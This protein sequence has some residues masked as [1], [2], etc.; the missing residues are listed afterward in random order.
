MLEESYYIEERVILQQL[1]DGKGIHSKGG[2]GGHFS[3][4]TDWLKSWDYCI[5][6][7][8][9]LYRVGLNEVEG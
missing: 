3:N 2:S 6:L 9:T 5:K 8:L 7:N 1:S 4:E